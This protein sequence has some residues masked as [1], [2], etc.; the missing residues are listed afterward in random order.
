V[1]FSP[2]GTTRPGMTVGVVRSE[3]T[4]IESEYPGPILGYDLELNSRSK[5]CRQDHSG[6][7]SS[8]ARGWGSA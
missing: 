5:Y 8:S 2:S 6:S 4:L 1:L 7:G 3:T